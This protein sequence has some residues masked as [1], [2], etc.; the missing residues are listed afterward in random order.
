MGPWLLVEVEA[1]EGG[2]GE[3]PMGQRKMGVFGYY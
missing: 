1:G 2:G 3:R